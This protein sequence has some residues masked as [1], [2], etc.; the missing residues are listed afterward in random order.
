MVAWEAF[1][2][3]HL[4][5]GDILFREADARV[6][7]GLF[8]FSRVAARIADSRYT[9]TGLFAWENG[10]PVVYDTSMG[11]ARRQPFGIWVLDNVGHLGIK[12]PKPPY[13]AAIPGAVSYCRTV[14][15][16]QVPFDSKLELGDS[17]FYCVELT[18]RAYQAAGLDLAEPV[19]MGDLPRVHEHR[20]VF[21]LAR[22][23]ASF[24]P[25]QRM[26]ATGNDSFGLWASP[27]LEE[28]YVSEDGTR[29][30]PSCLVVL[31]S[32]Q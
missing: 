21:L 18:S 27:A 17:R 31:P 22:L 4:Q 16:Q 13:R 9:H 8:P 24:H 6:L 25:D 32:P 10:E 1:A 12:R 19:R 14:Y 3:D 29:P 23:F 7:G 26:Y 20:L 2:R 30:D 11:G 15:E 5:T 28:V